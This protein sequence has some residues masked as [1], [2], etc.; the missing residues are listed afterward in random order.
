[1]QFFVY[2]AHKNRKYQDSLS[3]TYKD[4]YSNELYLWYTGL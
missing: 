3:P 1:M 2:Y 4:L